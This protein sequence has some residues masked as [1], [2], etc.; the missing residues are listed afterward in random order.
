MLL[1]LRAEE[2]ERMRA[3][4][5]VT[6][7]IGAGAVLFVFL[8]TMLQAPPVLPSYT[9]P[10]INLAWDHDPLWVDNPDPLQNVTHFRLILRSKTPGVKDSFPDGDRLPEA[11][12]V[13]DLPEWRAP[14][15]REWLRFAETYEAALR[16]CST[17]HI[18]ERDP[19]GNILREYDIEHCS[20]WSNWVT[21]TPGV[22][23]GIRA[24]LPPT[25]II[26]R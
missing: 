11:S 22:I 6:G 21:F 1:D 23:P 16:S 15:P 19:E 7:C 17:E 5:V 3:F 4:S 25:T 9:V 26:F 2:R 12:K 13:L 14:I 20:A 18:I 10:T 24:P 8:A